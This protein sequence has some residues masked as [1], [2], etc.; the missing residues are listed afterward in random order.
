MDQRTRAMSRI[1]V[2]GGTFDPIHYGHLAAAEE[3][4]VALDLER[5]IWVPALVSPHKVD[6]T[7]TAPHHR[8][9][10]TRL[11][12]A[13]NPHF[14]VSTVDLDRAG[15]SYTVDTLT[16]LQSEWGPAELYFIVGLDSLAEIATWHDPARL[17]R[18]CRIVA[19]SRPPYEVDPVSLEQALPGVTEHVVFLRVPL[20]DIASSD[21]RRRVREGRSIRY[22]VPPVVVDYIRAH[23]LYTQEVLTGSG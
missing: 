8:L 10:M 2:L 21:L 11:A 13:S 14:Q 9:A 17:V 5:V 20:L 6:Q 7:T 12:V 16:R 18:L 3:A 4:R 22:Y 1:G 15:P 19:V 23:E